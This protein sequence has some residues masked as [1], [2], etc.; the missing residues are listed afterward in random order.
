MKW[1]SNLNKIHRDVEPFKV[2]SNSKS[3][4]QVIQFRKDKKKNNLL[5]HSCWP[6]ELSI[7]WQTNVL[8]FLMLRREKDCFSQ[9]GRTIQDSPLTIACCCWTEGSV[10]NNSFWGKL[11]YCCQAGGDC[12]NDSVE[13]TV[14]S[15]VSFWKNSQHDRLLILLKF[16]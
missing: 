9:C 14:W 13:I 3:N 6:K 4:F 5:H 11:N 7:I 16:N 1:E 15:L 10:G 12:S 8:P 2:K